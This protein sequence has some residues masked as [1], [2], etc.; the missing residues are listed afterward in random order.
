MANTVPVIARPTIPP[1]CWKNE[2]L[3]LAAPIWVTGTLL[4]TIS[5]NAANIGPTP[6]PV[7]NIQAHRSGWG[8]STRSWVSSASPTAVVTIAPNMSRR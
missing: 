7:T 3:L 5:G 4:C 6:R 2:T 1:T 8:V